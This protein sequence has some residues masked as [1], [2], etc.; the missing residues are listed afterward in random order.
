MR[1]VYS[2]MAQLERE[3]RRYAVCTVVRTS[4]STPQV[5]GAKMVVDDLGRLTGTLGGGCVEGDAFDEARRVIG[6]NE[7]SLREYELTEELAWDTGLVCGGTMWIWIEPGERALKVGDRELL[8]DLLAASTGGRPVALATLLRKKG[9]DLEPA[10]RIFVES[11]GRTHG[12]LNEP[13]LDDKARAVAFDALRQGTARTVALDEQ[14][15]LLIEPVLAKPRLVIVGGGHV[16][17]A[18]A[19]MASLL[20]YEVTVIE[21]RAEF[22]TRERFPDGVEVMHADLA[23]TIETMDIGWNSFIVVATRGHK[24]DAH[25]LRAAVRTQARYVGLLGSRRKTILI[26]RMLREEGIPEERLKGVH[27]PVGL[28]L[29]GRTPAEIALSVL[30]E[31]SA[32]RYGGSGR[33]LR[34]SEKLYERAVMAPA[35]NG[36]G[37]AD[38]RED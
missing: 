22:A 6:T 31:L 3:G 28:D 29:G 38:R 19:R 4:G 10:S 21:D 7:T 34:L 24:L 13:A 15:E 5:V 37:G 12:R 26:E 32:E 1:E 11:E 16:G 14:H 9:K 35:A 18:I 20:D 33:P 36:G 17:L 30:A 25:A 8:G 27:A 2:R 23:K